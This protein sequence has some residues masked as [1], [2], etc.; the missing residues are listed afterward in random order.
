MSAAGS[1]SNE[2]YR[3][4]YGDGLIGLNEKRPVWGTC[5]LIQMRAKRLM[6]DLDFREDQSHPVQMVTFYNAD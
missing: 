3:C 1:Y 6:S 2:D 5:A 4:G